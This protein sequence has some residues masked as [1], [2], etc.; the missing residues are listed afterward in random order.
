MWLYLAALVGLYYLLRWYR[1]RQVVSHLRDKYVFITGCDS[2]FGNLLARQLDTRGLRVLAGCL[3][4]KGAEQL[5]ACTSDRLKTVSLDV[6]KTE[7]VT[8]AAQWVKEHV[9]DRGL[10]GLVNNAGISQPTAPN[11]WLTKQDFV[12]ILDV[13]LLGLIEVTLSLLSLVRKAR[14]RLV[15]VS[16]VMGRVSLSGGGYC[17]SKYGVEA[18]SDSLRRELAHFGV[19][20]AVIEPGYYKTNMTNTERV[21]QMIQKTW[22]HASPEIKEI[23]GQKFLASYLRIISEKHMARC[24]LNLSE[25]TGCMEHAL[26]AC[27]PRTR[28]CRTPPEG[29]SPPAHTGSRVWPR[30]L[31]SSSPGVMALPLSQGVMVGSPWSVDRPWRWHLYTKGGSEGFQLQPQAPDDACVCVHPQAMWLYLAALVG[32]YYLLRWYRERQVVS[33]LRD[34]YVFIT[35]CD[36]GF[37]NLLARQLDTRGLRVL[38]GCLTEKGAEQLRARTSDRLKTV[39]LDVTKTESVTAAAQ[40]VKEC[41]GDRG[42]WGLVNNAGISQPTAPNEWLTKQDFVTILDVNLLGLIEVTLSLLPLVRKARGRVVNVSSVMGRVSFLGGGY[43]ISKYGVEAFSDSLRRE[44]S[45]SG[46]K[47]V[48]I[49]PGYFKTAVTSKEIFLKNLKEVWSRTSIEVKQSYGEKFLASYMKPADLLEQSLTQDLAKVTDCMEHALTAC[50]PRT[51][52]SAG[53]DAKLLYLPLS[54][55]PTFLVD[56]MVTWGSPRPAN[57]L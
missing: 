6:T 48:L 14:G 29:A 24:S 44:L 37:G 55:M 12:T 18:F 35:G 28:V 34:K 41:V 11:E 8:A 49:E 3:T 16:S 57:A 23:Y 51:R 47:V 25:V 5:R 40:W 7:S 17:I 53:W 13:N 30:S 1:E 56:A 54:Y 42:L 31:R 27:H 2:G 26:T 39:S 50:H 45:Y 21:L 46:V 15:N 20:V 36:S 4:E 38:A 52:Y 33:H 10:W 9:G 32:L 19:K 43:C 22:D